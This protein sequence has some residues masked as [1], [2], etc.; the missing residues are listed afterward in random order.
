MLQTI[1]KTLRHCGPKVTVQWLDESA[2]VVQKYLAGQPVESV[3]QSTIK[4]HIALS[5]NLPRWI[6]EHL[7]RGIWFN[8]KRFIH[9][10]LT[11]LSVKR[12]IFVPEALPD[13]T[14][15]TSSS[16]IDT[17]DPMVKEF[18]WF[19]KSRFQGLL[20]LHMPLRTIRITPLSARFKQVHATNKAGPNGPAVYTAHWDAFALSLPENE[21]VRRN[22]L[23]YIEST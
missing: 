22:L 3:D 9:T 20:K 18:E 14:T 11:N 12:M 21:E 2:R 5:W 8:N 10:V 15:I 23:D 1:D 6:P 19:I 16:N 13:I 4:H 7:R 17:T